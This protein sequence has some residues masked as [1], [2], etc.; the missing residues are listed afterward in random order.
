LGGPSK[1]APLRRRASGLVGATA[2]AALGRRK[3]K[4]YDP[5]M[6]AQQTRDEPREG[7]FALRGL[8]LVECNER[9]RRKARRQPRRQR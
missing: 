7:V 3:A 1:A 6:L 5:D 8:D 9:R 2:A 4:R